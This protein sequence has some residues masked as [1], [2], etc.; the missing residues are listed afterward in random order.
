M[1]EGGWG[2]GLNP[3]AV[4]WVRTEEVG[5]GQTTWQSLDK[6]LH[7][8]NSAVNISLVLGIIKIIN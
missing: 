8:G 7:A 3:V 2:G 1:R 5:L 4:P 6:L